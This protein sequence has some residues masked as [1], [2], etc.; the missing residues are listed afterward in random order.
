M[1][2]RKPLPPEQLIALLE[3]AI[4]DAPPFVYQEKLTDSDIRWLGRADALL[5]ASGAIT[6]LVNFRAARQSLG[7]YRHSRNQLLIPL[8]DAY[9]KMELLVPAALQGAFIPGG[10]TW[11]GYAAI[12]KIM[13]IEC[14]DLLVVDPYEDQ[15][16]IGTPFVG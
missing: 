13:Q 3:A 8:H 5:E 14:D 2:G 10:D 11:N 12:V 15:R 6:A 9:S 7:H 1:I 16:A 4:R